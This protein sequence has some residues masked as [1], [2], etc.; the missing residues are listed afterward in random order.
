MSKYEKEFKQEA[1]GLCKAKDANKAEIARKL[2]V[3]YKTLCNWVY[4]SNDNLSAEE[5]AEMK[6][7]KKENARLKEE[8]E[9]LKKASQYCMPVLR[10][11]HFAKVAR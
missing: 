1:V 6:R 9:I 7:L 2:A 11:T 10:Y 8:N 5:K 4:A 3:E